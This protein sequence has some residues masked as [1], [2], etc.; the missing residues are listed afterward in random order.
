MP[1]Q[2]ILI[3]GMHC[4]SCEIVLEEAIGG[5]HGVTTVKVDSSKG[6]AVIEYGDD[7]PS[8][9]EIIRVITEAGYQPTWP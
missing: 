2:T 7:V 5:V 8:R 9:D 6:N 4:S 1:Q 3:G